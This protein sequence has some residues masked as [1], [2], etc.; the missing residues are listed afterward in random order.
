MQRNRYKNIIK[1]HAFVILAYQRSPYLEDCVKSLLAQSTKSEVL[2]ATS[3]INEHISDVAKRYHLKLVENKDFA[4]GIANDF[5]F[6]L[7]CLDSKFVTLAHQDDIYAEKY[8]ENILAKMDKKTIIAFTDCFEIKR[9]AVEKINLNL[10]VKRTLLFFLNFRIFQ[11]ASFFKRGCLSLGN[12]ICCPTVTFNKAFTGERLFS[13]E[14]KSNM[15]WQ[16]WEN[17]S[18]KQGRFLYINKPLVFHR[19]HEDSTT[20]EL[21][22]SNERT[23][24]DLRILEQFWPKWLAK[25]IANIYKRSEKNNN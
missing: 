4:K 6:A 12:P 23:K 5:E 15:D 17:L 10:F 8:L 7:S 19:I 14:F 25:I 13:S 9:G 21:I 2:I 24:E 22:L 11:A 18:R 1:D 3:T 16:A 20:S